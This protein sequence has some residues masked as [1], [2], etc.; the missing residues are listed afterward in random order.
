MLTDAEGGI[1]RMTYDNVGNLKSMTD[2]VLKVMTYDYNDRNER[3]KTTD[4]L[5]H[6][7][8]AT[9]DKVGN[10]A[11]QTDGM[12]HTCGREHLTYAMSINTQDKVRTSGGD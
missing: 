1:S 11:T 8:T 9:Y 4:A 5:G 10:L 7:T 6:T 2:P 12:L 3:V